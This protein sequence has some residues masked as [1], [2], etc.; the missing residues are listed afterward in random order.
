[1]NNENSA[2][3][4]MPPSVA[5]SAE[6]SSTVKMESK[7]EAQPVFGDHRGNF[8]KPKTMTEVCAT[9]K[10]EIKEEA[11]RLVPDLGNRH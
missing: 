10:E 8:S 9:M 11:K 2:T 7:D 4:K 1:M 6:N 5:D 3:A